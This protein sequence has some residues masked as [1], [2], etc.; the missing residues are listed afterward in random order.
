MFCYS[1]LTGPWPVH[2][3]RMIIGRDMLHAGM[4]YEC[5]DRLNFYQT[6][7]DQQTTFDNMDTKSHGLETVKV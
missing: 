3:I 5:Q 7:L 4:I 1:A 2:H 6:A